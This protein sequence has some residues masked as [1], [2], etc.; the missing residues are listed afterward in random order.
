[1]L[2]WDPAMGGLMLAGC[3]RLKKR[4][5]AAALDLPRWGFMAEGNYEE[6]SKL[7]L[8]SCFQPANF[9]G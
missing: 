4:P 3:S 7:D 9:E 2:G 1:V 6:I 8:F 5:S